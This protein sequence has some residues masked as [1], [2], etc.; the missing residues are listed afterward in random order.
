MFSTTL[1]IATR[2][3][4][5]RYCDRTCQVADYKV[6]HKLLCSTFAHPPTTIAFQHNAHPVEQFPLH[7]VFARGHSENVGCW[8]T[9]DGRVDCEYVLRVPNDVTSA[10][11]NRVS[12]LCPACGL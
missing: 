6:R 7:Q 3:R 10:R 8:V 12:I 9:V 4:A 1:I 5:A 2:R 11:S